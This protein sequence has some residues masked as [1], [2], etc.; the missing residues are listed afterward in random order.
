MASECEDGSIRRGCVLSL[1]FRRLFCVLAYRSDGVG[2]FLAYNCKDS[3][4]QPSGTA[5]FVFRDHEI[6]HGKLGIVYDPLG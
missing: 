3:S 6:L 2:R 5:L 4:I 1:V